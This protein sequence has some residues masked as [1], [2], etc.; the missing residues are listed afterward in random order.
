MFRS[1]FFPIFVA[2]FLALSSF[3]QKSEVRVLKDSIEIL[4]KDLSRVI[5]NRYYTRYLEGENIILKESLVLEKG[6]KRFWIKMFLAETTLITGLAIAKITDSWVPV[7]MCAGSFEI[8][9][10]MDKKVRFKK[11]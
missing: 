7:M 3:G 6:S 11:E 2:F 10:L 5:N 4:K 8:F 9:L 1:K